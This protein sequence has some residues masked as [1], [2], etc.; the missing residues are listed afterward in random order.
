MLRFRFYN[1]GSLAPFYRYFR[2]N[3]DLGD[4]F[5]TLDAEEI[6][7]I[8]IGRTGKHGYAYE[9]VECKIHRSKVENSYPLYRYV[10]DSIMD[11]FYTLSS[12]EIGTVTPGEV[13]K[14]GYKSEGVAGYCFITQYPG[15]IPLYR[16]W[17][18]VSGDHFYTTSYREIGTRT[19]GNVGTHG[20]RYGGVACFVIGSYK[21]EVICFQINSYKCIYSLYIIINITL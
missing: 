16:Y 14:H 13:G 11:H 5:Y 15:T 8:E 21:S 12:D 6:G 7:T 19:P 9:G 18:R 1:L 3:G 20:Y 2:K 10:K 17:D 4:H